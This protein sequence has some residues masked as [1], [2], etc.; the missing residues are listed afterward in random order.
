MEPFLT[1][2]R[3]KTFSVEKQLMIIR[4]QLDRALAEKVSGREEASL[5]RGCSAL[6]ESLNSADVDE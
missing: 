4:A 5:T 2:A 1:V 6:A 3:G